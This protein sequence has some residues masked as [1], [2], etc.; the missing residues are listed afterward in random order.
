MNA[1]PLKRRSIRCPIAPPHHVSLGSQKQK[2]LRSSQPS[3][4]RDPLSVALLVL[5]AAGGK[6]S[7]TSGAPKVEKMSSVCF[8][9]FR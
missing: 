5:S 6:H 2:K 9:Q 8:A 4:P 1:L 7:Q 3:P